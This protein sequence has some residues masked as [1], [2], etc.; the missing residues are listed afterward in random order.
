MRLISWNCAQKAHV[1]IPEILALRPDILVLPECARPEIIR[2]KNPALP[3]WSAAWVGDNPQKGLGVFAFGEYSVAPDTTV[4]PSGAY[5]LP[6][7]CDGPLQMNLLATWA[8][9]DSTPRKAVPNA[10]SI[11]RVVAECREF[12][13]FPN[14]VMAGDFNASIL[15][16]RPRSRSPFADVVHLLA[17]LGLSS[18][19]HAKYPWK[20]GQEK[21]PTFFDRTR[22]D[23]PFHIDYVF[24]KL[25]AHLRVA[26]VSIGAYADWRRHSDHMP[27]LVE[28][29]RGASR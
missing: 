26:D 25:A 20:L 6:V 27:I 29:T 19:V 11:R 1:R 22:A 7:R 17:E 8:L 2:T 18:A 3:A 14:A 28:F 13:S 4:L 21:A 12:L 15:W 16:D 10:A 9:N 23:L 5:F 24:L